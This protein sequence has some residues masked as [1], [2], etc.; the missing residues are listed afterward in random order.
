[1]GQSAQDIFA[2]WDD[3]RY[4]VDIDRFDEQHK[5]LFGLLN[6]LHTAM[7]EGHS[8]EKVGDILRELERYTDYHFG[9]EEE[10]M[11][12]CGYAMDC[13]DCFY[14]HREA[15]EE[16]A[17][18]VSELREKHENGEYITMEVLTFVRDWL[19]SHI[20]ASDV[21]QN[22]SDY[23]LEEVEDYEYNPG[24]LKSYRNEGGDS[25]TERAPDQSESTPAEYSLTVASETVDGGDLVVPDESM[26]S[27]FEGVA[28]THGDR[29]AALVEVEGQYAARTFADLYD[30]ARDV[31][32]G[33][34]ADAFK[35]GDRVA[36]VA[37]SNYEWSVV[38]LACHLAGFV[39]VPI[40]P[41]LSDER[42]VEIIEDAAV[43]GLVSEVGTAVEIEE[44]AETVVQIESLPTQEPRTLPGFEAAPDDVATIVFDAGRTDDHPG[45]TLTHRNLL[46]AVAT[47]GEE[48]PL[49]AGRTGT[50]F[51]PLSHVYQRVLTYYLW[52]SGSAVA[53]MDTGNF[54]R[55]LAVVE[56]DVLVGTPKLYQEL[57]GTLQDRIGDLGWMK[58]KLAGRVTAYGRGIV[59]GSGTPLK[60]RAAKRLVFGPLREQFGLDSLDYALSGAGRLDDHLVYFFR[61]F[62]V[63]VTELHGPIEAAGVAT[64]NPAT[65]YEPGAVGRPV[66]G[67]ELAVS[68]DGD[69]VMQGPS[70]MEGYLDEG[71]TAYA[72]RDDWLLTGDSGRF[73]ADGYLRRETDE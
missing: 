49:G 18:R 22:Y 59:D 43:D 29:T 51:L 70:V 34:L 44:A 50:C 72:L 10:F 33:L 41:S 66:A 17:E 53:Y 40:Y 11:Q 54:P 7:N 64:L 35:P 13:A 19:D 68:E 52:A 30:R 63:P 38:D 1:M 24:Q 14:N 20:A 60:Y 57:Y 46:A 69:V 73:D 12:D 28:E 9:D 26:A 39:S 48:L 21:D 5:R 8:E 42:I 37:A 62:G 65:A 47:L 67:T 2:E 71:A 55:N 32:G 3:D 58:R 45:C 15:H 31:A 27:W 25:V 61:G 36:I 16:F 56:P 23:Y 4:S 6:D